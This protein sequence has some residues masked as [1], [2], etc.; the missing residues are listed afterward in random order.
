M[1]VLVTL[2]PVL[3]A[4]RG[5][6]GLPTEPSFRSYGPQRGEFHLNSAL[7]AK[8]PRRESVRRTTNKGTHMTT[9]LFRS[10]LAT[11]LLFPG[12]W[13]LSAAENGT[14]LDALQGAWSLTKTNAQGQPYRQVLDFKKD[15]VTFKIQGLDG[16]LYWMATG[17]ARTEKQGLFNVLIAENIKGGPSTNELQ[18]PAGDDTTR[19]SVYALRQGNLYLA[20]NFD[21][22]RENQLPLTDVYSRGDPAGR[23][24]AE[25]NDALD[26]L[27]GHWNL[28][29]AFQD[30]KLP[31]DL[32]L[33]RRNGGLTGTLV[34][35]RT[36]EHPIRSVTFENGELTMEMDRN[37]G[38][39][40]VVF[41]YKGKFEDGAL[42]GTAGIKDHE[43]QLHGTWT[44]SK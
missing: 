39:N 25:S 18:P 23:A 34:S 30:N 15:Q 22:G 38:G 3:P 32:H 42:S 4:S 20:A 7:D 29:F 27:V 36:G 6:S 33:A 41:V 40:E 1:V 28:E 17:T 16:Q 43:D 2:R 26:K 24:A 19:A 31:Y 10:I 35:P 14:G 12:S 9:S 21:K 5:R 13:L 44:A 37:F 11:A 8:L